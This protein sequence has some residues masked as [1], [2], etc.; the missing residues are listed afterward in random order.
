M[1]E[2]SR[3][4]GILFHVYLTQMYLIYVKVVNKYSK[5]SFFYPN[6][7]VLLNI[8]LLNKY[9]VSALHKLES[10]T[11]TILNTENSNHTGKFKKR[12][13]LKIK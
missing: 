7:C 12:L 13:N 5:D 4:C 11:L 8:L 1:I 3:L 2:N 9:V 10:S 6:S